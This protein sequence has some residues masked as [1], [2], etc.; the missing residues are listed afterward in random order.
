MG[1]DT[2]SVASCNCSSYLFWRP[3]KINTQ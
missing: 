1:V 3:P 2:A